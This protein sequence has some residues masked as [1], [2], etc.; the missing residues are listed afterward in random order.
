META[1]LEFEGALL[2][3][4]LPKGT[5]GPLCPR[6]PRGPPI[7]PA[8]ITRHR[9]PIPCMEVVQAKLPISAA[10]LPPMHFL[11]P[12]LESPSLIGTWG[13]SPPTEDD[14]PAL[15]SFSAC[16]LSPSLAACSCH[17]NTDPPNYSPFQSPAAN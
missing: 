17:G 14:L 2:G 1:R 12:P 15:L 7:L 6:A 8:P 5:I 11:L 16:K 4:E 13:L 10:A 3:R 9:V